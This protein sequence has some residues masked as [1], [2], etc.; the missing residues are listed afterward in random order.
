M[1]AQPKHT[2]IRFEDAIEFALLARGYAKG[3]P[4]LFDAERAL[5]PADVVTYI[6]A[7]QPRKWQSL[8][9][10]QGNAAEATALMPW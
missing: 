4:D 5:F 1:T 9:D 8:V 6:Q 10:L 3:N 2:E 7:S